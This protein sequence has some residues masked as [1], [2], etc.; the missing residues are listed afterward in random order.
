MTKVL[1]H[2]VPETAD[3]W[4]PLRAE[5]AQRGVDDVV[6]LSP[7][8]FGAP[9]PPGWSATPDAYVDWLAE[10]IERLGPPVDVLGHD[11]GTGHVL[12]LALR[13]PDLLRSWC[14]DVA[15]LL[16]PDYEWHELAQQWQI[17]EVGEQVIE[18]MLGL[19]A[20]DRAAAYEAAGAVDRDIA[21]RMAEAMDPTMGACILT[22]YR[23]GAQ[24]YVRRLGEELVTARPGPGLVLT[25]T[26]DAYVT[27]DHGREMAA[28]LDARHVS[29]TGQ[30]HWW[31]LSRPDLAA[32]ALTDFWCR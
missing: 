16:H 25:A 18:A 24:P 31:M 30:G 13:R 9:T 26:E 32:E 5:L 28:R 22:L 15:G 23:H 11:W 2:G 29:L 12:G 7:P 3:I 4:G 20:A 10:E 21:R 14:V 6:A 1:V 19:S 8:G 27:A 17:P